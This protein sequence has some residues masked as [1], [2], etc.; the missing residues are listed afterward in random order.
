MMKYAQFSLHTYQVLY[1]FDLNDN[2][3]TYLVKKYGWYF[4][5]CN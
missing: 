2:E 5:H 1:E 4:I 3:I